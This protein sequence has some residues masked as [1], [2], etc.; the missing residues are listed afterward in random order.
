MFY[1]IC[2]I[3]YDKK[4]VYKYEKYNRIDNSMTIYI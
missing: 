2:S 3:S 4:I 1:K